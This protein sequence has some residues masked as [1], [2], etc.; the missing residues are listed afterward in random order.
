MSDKLQFV[1]ALRRRPLAKSATN[2]SLSDIFRRNFGLV[3]FAS[4]I[5]TPAPLV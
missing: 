2:W 3:E 5:E 1:V 4:G